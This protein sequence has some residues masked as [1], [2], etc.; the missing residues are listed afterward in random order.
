MT[1]ITADT[2]STLS[3]ASSADTEPDKTTLESTTSATTA[4]DASNQTSTEMDCVSRRTTT[5][6]ACARHWEVDANAPSWSTQGTGQSEPR[7]R[8]LADEGAPSR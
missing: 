3:D 1:K 7:R 2:K 6:K 5:R 8:A 4:S